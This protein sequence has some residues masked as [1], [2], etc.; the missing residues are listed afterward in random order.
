MFQLWKKC[1]KRDET[2]ENVPEMDTYESLKG[3]GSCKGSGGWSCALISSRT[4][5]EIAQLRTNSLETESLLEEESTAFLTPFSK[6]N[7]GLSRTTLER[8]YSKIAQDKTR[9]RDW[10]PALGTSKDT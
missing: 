9:E 6:K 2:R 4:A 3:F 7:K 1:L 5:L 8:V 10:I